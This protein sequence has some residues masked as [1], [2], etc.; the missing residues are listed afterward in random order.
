MPVPYT[1]EEL[2]AATHELIARQRAARVLHPPDRLPR[3]RPD[4]AQP[5]RL[6]GLGLDRGLAVGRLPRRGLG[7]AR[8]P[9]QGLE[10]AADLVRLADP[11][12]QGLAASTSTACWP[13]SRRPR[14]ATRRRSCS[15]P[16]ASCPRAPARTST[17][18]ATA[19]SSRRRR[20][21]A[22][23]TGSTASRSS[24]SPRDLGYEVVERNL[25]R[26]EL[27]LADE[28]FLSGTAAELVPVREIDDH[29]IGEG[30][31]GPI[32]RAIQTVF[33][34]ALHGR[35]DALP[36]VARRRQ[37]AVADAPR[38][39]AMTGSSCTTPPCATGCRARGCRCRRTRSCAS[40][41]GS[42]SS[43]ST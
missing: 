14:P 41:T 15:T 19:S 36:R 30:V 23:S 9:R 22:S 26:A 32:T 42:T 2:R 18:S 43:G 5:A 4:G 12:R 6:R 34:D 28:V 27:Y 1:L 3:L 39:R 31:A 11:A 38:P 8:D 21:P 24:R 33:D 37:G 17:S 16:R 7:D 40:R 13:R 29:T 35:D 10:L 20:P 25:A